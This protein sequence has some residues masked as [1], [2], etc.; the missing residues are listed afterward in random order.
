[1]FAFAVILILSCGINSIM[2][3][4]PYK[5]CGS[6]LGT[7]QSFDVSGCTSAPCK[8]VKGQTYSMNLTLLA[9]TASKSASVKLFGNWR[10]IIFVIRNRISLFPISGVIGGIPVPF[11]LPNPD[12]CKL[13]V[14]CPVK[15]NDVDTASFSLPVLTSY[16]SLS[17]YVKL[18]LRADDVS[19]DYVCLLFPA[20]ITSWFSCF[21]WTLRQ[22]FFEE[23][24]SSRINRWSF[25]ILYFFL[26]T[27]MWRNLILML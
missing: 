21:C 26:R 9:K 20:T 8:L 5:D 16:P 7:I 13:G 1:M 24:H 4:T 3:A 22:W 19:Q 25:T 11:P 18:E 6:E 10:K 14:V 2:S 23:K 15:Q 27:N 12:A 17:L